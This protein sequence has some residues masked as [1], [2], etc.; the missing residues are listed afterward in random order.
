MPTQSVLKWGNSLAVRIP[1]PFARELQVVEG[2]EVELRLEGRTL[3]VQRSAQSLEFTHQAL[4]KALRKRKK[5]AR[6]LGAARS[7]E[8]S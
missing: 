1:A 8:L 7:A 3:V 2:S 5:S 4:A 6:R